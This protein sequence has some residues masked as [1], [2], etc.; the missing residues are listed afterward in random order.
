[1]WKKN[2]TENTTSLIYGNQQ[3]VGQR[4]LDFDYMSHRKTPSIEAFVD[5]SK[6]KANKI[7]LFF[8]KK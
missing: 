7:P 2:I 8:G 1:M 3:Q 6:E 4:C 5:P